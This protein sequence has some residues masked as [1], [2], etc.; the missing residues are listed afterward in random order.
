MRV[1][2]IGGGPIPRLR[3]AKTMLADAIFPR[4]C[5]GC[6]QEGDILCVTCGE[7]WV[8]DGGVAPLLSKEGPGV[9][10][11]FLAHYAD[12]IAR[13]LLTNWKYHFDETAWAVLSRRLHP[14]LS[15][16]LLRMAMAK[17]TAI[18]PVPLSRE[19]R[20]ERGFDQAETIATWLSRATK[21]PVV[22][23]LERKFTSGHQAE[24]STADR[25][26]AMST[27]PFHFR[28]VIGGGPIPRSILLVDDVW[29]T[30]AT[31]HA[32]IR[33][34]NAGGIHTVHCFS[35]LKGG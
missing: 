33:T 18:V 26:T 23:M 35:L 11:W 20:A 15:T 6:G 34:L 12:P 16:L 13:G 10:L 25:N 5:V 32:A 17:I 14:S 27:S 4:F 22:H 1:Q 30:G 2:V 8:P 31:M 3:D 29:T 24:R 19:R 9:V 21:I 28:N 7:V